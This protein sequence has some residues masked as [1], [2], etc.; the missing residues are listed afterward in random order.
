MEYVS[1]AESE[2]EYG[3][4]Y[5]TED[6]EIYAKR[7]NEDDGAMGV[8]MPH[9]RVAFDPATRGRSENPR[10]T[11][12]TASVNP[13][14]NINGNATNAAPRKPQGLDRP[15]SAPEAYTRPP[16]PQ[17]RGNDNPRAARPAPQVTRDTVVRLPRADPIP[18]LKADALAESK[19]KEMAIKACRAITVDAARESGTVVAAAKI[20]AAGQLLGDPQVVG[21]GKEL[22]RRV[23]TYT[24]K[25]ASAL[26]SKG[27][28]VH[29]GHADHHCM[30]LDDSELAAYREG[31]SS[32]A[33]INA[34]IPAAPVVSNCKAPVQIAGHAESLTAIVDTGASKSAITKGT[35]RRLG[36]TKYI[37]PYQ[38]FYFNADGR[39]TPSLGRIR[40]VPVN[41]GHLTTKVSF[42]V[43]DAMTYDVLL[44]MDFLKAGGAILD[45]RSDCIRYD[46]GDG[47]EGVSC[48]NC[49]VQVAAR[50][51]DEASLLDLKEITATLNRI[52]D[53]FM[54]LDEK[55]EPME[56]PTA[57]EG[58]DQH[59]LPL[60]MDNVTH[61]ISADPLVEP[62]L[63]P[64][65]STQDPNLVLTTTPPELMAKVMNATSS[66][67]DMGVCTQPLSGWVEDLEEVV[68]IAAAQ[69]VD[70]SEVWDKLLHMRYSSGSDQHT[71][72]PLSP[73]GTVALENQEVE[74][75]SLF[76][77]DFL[78]ISVER[79][80][81][82]QQTGMECAEQPCVCYSPVS[83]S[84]DYYFPPY[85]PASPSHD[86]FTVPWII[87]PEPESPRLQPISLEARAT[88]A[89]DNPSLETS[90]A[91]NGKRGDDLGGGDDLPLS[92]IPLREEEL[93]SVFSPGWIDMMHDHVIPYVTTVPLKDI[94]MQPE[95][96][97]RGILFTFWATMLR[98]IYQVG[99]GMVWPSGL[100]AQLCRR[101]NLE[102]NQ[103][104]VATYIRL[105]EEHVSRHIAK[106]LL[107]EEICMSTRSV[108]ELAAEY[109]L[110]STHI[111]QGCNEEIQWQAMQTQHITQS[112]DNCNNVTEQQR[113]TS[114]HRD[115]QTAEEAHVKAMGGEV[116]CRGPL[117]PV[118][119]PELKITTVANRCGTF[120][121]M[122]MSPSTLVES[123]CTFT[124]DHNTVAANLPPDSASVQADLHDYMEDQQAVGEFEQ[125]FDQL[126]PKDPISI[127]PASDG[128]SNS[129]DGY[130]WHHPFDSSAMN[131][132]DSDSNCGLD[133]LPPLAVSSL[134]DEDLLWGDQMGELKPE[135]MMEG[136][137]QELGAAE[138][139]MHEWRLPIVKNAGPDSCVNRFVMHSV[140][141]P[142]E[143]YTLAPGVGTDILKFEQSSDPTA[144]KDYSEVLL[145][146]S[147]MQ[148]V[149]EDTAVV[150]EDSLSSQ[151]ISDISFEVWIG[152]DAS[153]QGQDQQPLQPMIQQES[154]SYVQLAEYKYFTNEARGR[155]RTNRRRWRSCRL[156]S[157]P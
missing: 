135:F 88:V 128:D 95:V 19:G 71:I 91:C 48:L 153:Q 137:T 85:S 146:E 27:T 7:A 89:P 145:Q 120:N 68:Q 30:T 72:T 12:G 41:L 6:S 37:E 148:S 116:D 22:A 94:P 150:R 15:S 80:L 138:R 67:G 51:E 77:E 34:A 154:S 104:G 42:S 9:K 79:P 99:P 121:E 23:D 13:T 20:V 78:R 86:T 110:T 50:E 156:Q 75:D 18:S 103:E 100:L 25:Q 122:L 96:V 142:N 129:L 139:L 53:F 57:N 32:T 58:S 33:M 101:F 136:V 124:E 10:S 36:L 127:G 125:S 24:Q 74:A 131:D 98:C 87:R 55:D 134:S 47:L 117:L 144:A 4:T 16:P 115:Q 49:H 3:Y 46:L 8:R 152:A 130:A 82:T 111:S 62:K 126:L 118:R 141:C 5:Q 105:Y 65:C 29:M 84:A 92:A 35:L 151:Q 83:S 26:L 66:L 97:G 56:V 28:D 60:L 73:A 113:H 44:G 114:E 133:Q 149:A 45:L 140:I 112:N 143:I 108:S 64:E 39:K 38:S 90:P 1:D 59:L 106:R 123:F 11:N 119:F 107:G 157:V 2:P 132:P 109:L 31:N 43:T 70:P 93:P 69:G 54:V 14:M 63:Y 147:D 61:F 17:H 81:S 76:M 102:H 155:T 40:D 52:S 21:I